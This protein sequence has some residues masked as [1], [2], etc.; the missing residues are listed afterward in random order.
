MGWAAPSGAKRRRQH[1]GELEARVPSAAPAFLPGDLCRQGGSWVVWNSKVL[2]WGGPGG[3]EQWQN[4][5]SW[6]R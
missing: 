5:W 1:S 6:E 2:T 3:C 4:G